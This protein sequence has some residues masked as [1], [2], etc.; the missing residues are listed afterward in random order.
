MVGV[1]WDPATQSDTVVEFAV[2]ID[3]ERGNVEIETR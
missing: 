2:S 1:V 3:W